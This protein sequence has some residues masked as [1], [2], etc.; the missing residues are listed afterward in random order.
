MTDEIF[1]QENIASCCHCF[2][3]ILSAAMDGKPPSYLSYYLNPLVKAG[4]LSLSL[5]PLIEQKNLGTEGQI[6]AN[7]FISIT[8]SSSMG[9]PMRKAVGKFIRN[10]GTFS[11]IAGQCS[12]CFFFLIARPFLIRFSIYTVQ[13]IFSRKINGR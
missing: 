6:G 2:P 12:I 8:K 13:D 3:L 11:G 10:G 7:V 5:S 4:H 1:V 9:Y